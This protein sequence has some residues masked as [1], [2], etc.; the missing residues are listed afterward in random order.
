MTASRLITL[1][2]CFNLALLGAAAFLFSKRQPAFGNPGYATRIMS[3]NAARPVVLKR[4]QPRSTKA[5]SERFTWDRLQSKDYKVYLANLREVQCPEETIQ[6]IIIAAVNQEYNVREASLKL[7]PQHL[8]PWDG[9]ES[10]NSRNWDKLVQL[11][12]LLQEK[13][14]LLKELLGVDVPVEM[15]LI[16]SRDGHVKFEAALS[17]LPEDKREAVR[18][19]Q[20][21]FWIDTGRLQQRTTKQFDSDDRAGICGSIERERAG[22]C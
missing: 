22:G 11:R 3:T 17:I 14:A 18:A 12:E 20:E 19:I 9:P 10:T 4:A 2:I 6:D 21:K 7:R 16:R 8:K 15:P 1:L 5:A 13:H